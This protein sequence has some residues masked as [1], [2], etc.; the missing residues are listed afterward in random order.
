MRPFNNIL[1]I[2]TV[3]FIFSSFGIENKNSKSRDENYLKENN[4]AEKIIQAKSLVNSPSSTILKASRNNLLD[5]IKKGLEPVIKESYLLLRQY[6]RLHVVLE[7]YQ[8]IERDKLW[9]KIEIDS[10]SFKDLQS[11]DNGIAIKQIRE[12]LFVVGDLKKD[13]KSG[14]YDEELM[15]GVL[16]YKKRY[17]LAIN[18][19]FTL[20][21][22]NQMNEPI[23]NRINT[24]KLN[25]LRCLLIPENLAN[26]SDYIMVNIPSYRLL[27]VKNGVNELVS[28]VFVGA[29]WSETKIMNSSMDKIVFSPYWNIPK[30]IVDHELRMNI[31]WDKDYLKKNDIEWNGGNPRQKPGLKNSLG[32][33]KF[34]FP[35]S[36]DIY[37]HDTPTKSLFQFEKRTF[38]HGCI[39]IKDGKALAYAI[40]KDDPN[41][42]TETIDKAMSGEK[43]T[44]YTLKNKIPVYV[45]YFTAWVNEE[46]GEISFFHDVYKKDKEFKDSDNSKIIVMN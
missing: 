24:I 14:L 13:S 9:K 42:S 22:I 19:I 31:A 7:K 36:Y 32:L 40:L 27:Y 44:I 1:L 37:M 38:S 16:N 26:A 21:D 34:L 28:D 25:M 29:T 41:W 33:V 18:Y 46:T 30:S 45:A 2:I 11:S 23:S 3:G 43:E 20:E 17:G 6:D 4:I 5:T 10:V 8:K 12:R 15:A 35:N 39:N